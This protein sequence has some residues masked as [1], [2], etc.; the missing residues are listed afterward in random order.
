MF[1]RIGQSL[2]A[3]FVRGP[4]SYWQK[5]W[6][7][8]QIYWGLLIAAVEYVLFPDKTL[9]VALL[10]VLGAAMLDIITRYF[11]VR[12]LGLGRWNSEEF[13][14]GTGVK[15]VAYLVISILAGLSYRLTP[16]LQQP[17]VYLWSVAYVVMFLREVQSNVENLAE[18][19]ADVGWLGT[20]AK[21]KE[22]QILNRTEED[23]TVSS[24]K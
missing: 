3:F 24:G 20:W 5:A 8:V 1:A 14:Q 15:L 22:R 11:A 16:F 13:W 12:K 6:S 19:G 9:L 7:S 17:T 18:L 4:A 2:T 10:S 21:R 23:E